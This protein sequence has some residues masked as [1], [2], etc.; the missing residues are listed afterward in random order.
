M[1]RTLNSVAVTTIKYHLNSKLGEI[2]FCTNTKQGTYLRSTIFRDL[3]SVEC[4]FHKNAVLG[5][6]TL[7]D[8]T[9]WLTQNVGTQLQFYAE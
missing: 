3:R 9:G 2:C 5:C 7:E 1:M 6:F 8:G 4:L